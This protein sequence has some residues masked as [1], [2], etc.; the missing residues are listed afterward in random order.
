MLDKISTWLATPRNLRSEAV[1]H[2]FQVLDRGQCDVLCK[3]AGFGFKSNL[4]RMCPRFS[5]AATAVG[6]TPLRNLSI[7]YLNAK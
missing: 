2:K 7:K 1:L 6:Q 4:P 5:K 3:L